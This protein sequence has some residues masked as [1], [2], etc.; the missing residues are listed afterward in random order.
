LLGRALQRIVRHW[1]ATAQ[2][3]QRVLKDRLAQIDAEK[4]CVLSRLEQ[5]DAEKERLTYE[6]LIE[7]KRA[8]SAGPGSYREDLRKDCRQRP[9][10]SVGTNSELAE[11]LCAAEAEPPHRLSRIPG[12]SAWHRGRDSASLRDDA[13]SVVSEG[14]SLLSPSLNMRL[15]E[16]LRSM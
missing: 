6:L 16:S 3:D 7:Q 8:A 1:F 2:A 14:H 15:D 10:S 9:A 11:L 5:I 12:S 13:S 4:Q